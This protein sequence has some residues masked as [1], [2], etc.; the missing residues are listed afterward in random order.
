MSHD[1]AVSHNWATQAD[2][3]TRDALLSPTAA[4]G[5]VRA[6]RVVRCA[7]AL[8]ELP[9]EL[10]AKAGAAHTGDGLGKQARDAIAG[11]APPPFPACVHARTN[12]RAP[13]RT[14]CMPVLRITG[15]LAHA[16]AMAAIIENERQLT[17]WDTI[18][19]DG[20]CGL[21]LKKARAAPA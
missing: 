12:A 21:T 7:A 2:A 15:R 1:S 5:W 17:E 9:H 20:D 3:P 8:V 13:V 4:A 16:G 6:Q 10:V 18:S 11:P 19:G 14:R